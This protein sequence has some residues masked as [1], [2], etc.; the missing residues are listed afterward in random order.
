M[1][2]P[3]SERSLVFVVDDDGSMRTAIGR[4]LRSNGFDVET[5]ES[6]RV[7]LDREPAEVPCCLVLD[8][9]MPELSGLDLQQALPQA[10]IDIPIV[11]VTGHGD[12][13]TTVRAMKSGAEDFLQK[14][15][16]ERELL[17]AVSRALE[18][19]R[20]ARKTRVELRELRR[21]AE[22]LTPREREVFEL[23]VTGILN[24][25]VAFELG[26]AEKTIKVHR[27]RVMQKMKADSLAELVRMAG[28]L[29]I[30]SE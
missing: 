26:A 9:R 17:D 14:P 24:K 18:R 1:E 4:L 27:G 20:A 7:F 22:S 25:Q 30:G 21:R 13:P 23:V 11:F 8:V 10:G 12:V 16:G 29:G 15:F 2:T 6:A 19:D 5:F 3:A 28:K